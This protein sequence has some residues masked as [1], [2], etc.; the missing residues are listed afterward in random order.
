MLGVRRIR[1]N[2]KTSLHLVA[3]GPVDT[4]GAVSVGRTQESS[5]DI[6]RYHVENGY[7]D[8]AALHREPR[9]TL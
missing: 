8:A 2:I 5:T 3:N 1:A 9:L 4:V 6:A 7:R